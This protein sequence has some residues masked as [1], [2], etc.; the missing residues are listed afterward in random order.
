MKFKNTFT[1]ELWISI[2]LIILLLSAYYIFTCNHENVEVLFIGI[3]SILV[4]PAGL[5][6]LYLN[7][8]FHAHHY[9]LSHESFFLYIL[10]NW[11]LFTV[12]GYFQWFVILPKMINKCKNHGC[13]AW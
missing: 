4:F 1:L 3:E 2:Q 5:I 9:F 7:D 6:T 8:I 11:I 13:L 12:I 10:L